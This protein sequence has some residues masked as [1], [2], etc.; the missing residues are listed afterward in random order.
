MAKRILIL[1]DE[2]EILTLMQSRLEASGYEVISAHDGE[3]GLK[4]IKNSMPDLIITD[5]A[6]PQMDG[7]TFIQEVKKNSD[8]KKVPVIVLTAKDSLKDIFKIEGIV[9]YVVKPFE[10]KT[11]LEKVNKYI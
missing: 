7:F 3:E 10:T 4:I 6:M 8:F 1:D 9:D 2:P 5:V 11:L